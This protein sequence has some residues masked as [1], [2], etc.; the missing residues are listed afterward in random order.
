MRTL[1]VSDLHL[2]S[3]DEFDIFAGG[4][5]LAA[6]LD[7]AA[8]EP[9]RVVVAGDGI[10]FLLNE[11]PLEFDVERAVTQARAAVAGA[12]TGSTLQAMGRVL[13][14]GGEVVIRLGN[15][16]VELADP[17]VQAVV[18]D[19]LGQPP[20]VAARLVF[21]LGDEPMLVDVGKVRVLVAHG[22]HCDPWNKVDYKHLLAGPEGGMYRDFSYSPG[23]RL[24]KTLLNPLK[25]QFGMR[26]ADLLKPDFQG[27]VMTALAVDPGAVRVLFSGSTLTLAWQLFR[28][29]SGPATFG[30]G[31]AETGLADRIEELGL[32]ADEQE[33]LEGLLGLVAG[34]TFFSAGDDEV[35]DSALLKAGKGGLALYARAQR[36]M[37]GDAGERFFDLTPSDDEWTEAGRLAEKF[38]ADAVVLGHSHAARFRHD[39]K[40]TYVNTGTWIWLMQLPAEDALDDEWTEFLTRLRRNPQLDPDR[41]PAAPTLRRLTAA[42]FDPEEDGRARLRLVQW[43]GDGE[44]RVLQETILTH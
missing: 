42:V 1:I 18:R 20:D 7:S 8:A 37:A 34:P 44:E 16:D 9:T 13:E 23:S 14:R 43:L 31:E 24:V 33:A 2:G 25:V 12:D 35:T 32:S 6:F 36:S 15:H 5:E 27:A 38:E 4:E 30:E 28:R 3:G 11:D 39:P 10:D 17:D 26:F 41:G 29:L 21:E 40:L 19:A 22:D